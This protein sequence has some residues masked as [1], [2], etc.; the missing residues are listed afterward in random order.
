M[1]QTLKS[2]K[3]WT[4]LGSVS[5]DNSLRLKASTVKAPF[6]STHEK[7]RDLLDL[8]RLNLSRKDATIL[9]K[10]MQDWII[11]K[12]DAYPVEFNETVDTPLS[13]IDKSSH[14]IRYFAREHSSA[15][16]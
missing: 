6:I 1:D 5:F 14:A 8:L 4:S 12:Q 16:E 9:E 3:M 2:F 10:G 15:Q 7:N 13:F 11:L